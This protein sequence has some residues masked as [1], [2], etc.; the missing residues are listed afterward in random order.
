M[1]G[2]EL[3]GLLA[4]IIKLSVHLVNL[5]SWNDQK[6]QDLQRQKFLL[7]RVVAK[8]PCQSQQKKTLSFLKSDE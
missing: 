7:Q 8:L 6:A 3:I 4:E 5:Y 2:M 1:V